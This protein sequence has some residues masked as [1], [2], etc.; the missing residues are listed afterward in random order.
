M[1]APLVNNHP[2]LLGNGGNN[3]ATATLKTTGDFDTQVQELSTPPP[4]SFTLVAALQLL[5]PFDTKT[6]VFLM[7]RSYLQ[8]WL[9]WAYHQQVTKSETARVDAALKLAAERYGLTPP[10]E[11][12]RHNMEYLDPGPMDNGFLSLEGHDLLLSP[13]VVVREG[14]SALFKQSTQP[15]QDRLDAEFPELLRRVKSLPNA[16]GKKQ[17]DSEGVVEDTVLMDD[18]TR[19]GSTVATHEDDPLD[20]LDVEGENILCCAVPARFYEVSDMKTHY[21]LRCG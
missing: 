20:S 21:K 19:G 13:N 2:P 18:P 15:H 4:E 9:L 12:L 6:K 1:T 8:N 10:Q 5:D 3:A 17:T 7:T 11:A 14:N 16:E